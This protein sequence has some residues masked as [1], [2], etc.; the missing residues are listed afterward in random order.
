LAN[1]DYFS[2]TMLDSFSRLMLAYFSRCSFIFFKIER[3]GL[4]LFKFINILME[5]N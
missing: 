5:L 2:R 4:F 1:F 3:I